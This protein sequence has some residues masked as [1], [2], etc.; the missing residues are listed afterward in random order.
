MFGVNNIPIRMSDGSTTTIQTI[1]SLPIDSKSSA[2]SMVMKILGNPDGTAGSIFIDF[3]GSKDP[4]AKYNKRVTDVDVAVLTGWGKHNETKSGKS[5]TPFNE[6]AMKDKA[7]DGLK[8]LQG[9]GPLICTEAEEQWTRYINAVRNSEPNRARYL[10]SAIQIQAQFAK[11]HTA[12]N[13][14]S[15]SLMLLAPATKI[16]K[17]TGLVDDKGRPISGVTLKKNADFADMIQVLY[18]NIDKVKNTYVIGEYIAI[19]ED[20]YNSD[21]NIGYYGAEDS[22]DF[23]KKSGLAG[24]FEKD[25]KKFEE[26]QKTINLIKHRLRPDDDG[27]QLLIAVNIGQPQMVL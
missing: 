9:G 1:G 25:I 18:D 4:L 3:S 26:A 15:I 8:S 12:T 11:S 10:K 14:R 2:Q 7:F 6:M 17:E 5:P 27:G 13:L 22:I 23:L 16:L 20:I 19:M 21:I 24:G